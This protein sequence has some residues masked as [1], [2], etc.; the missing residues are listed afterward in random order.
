MGSIYLENFQVVRGS[1]S[2]E[3]RHLMTFY[4]VHSPVPLSGLLAL[5]V[6]LLLFSSCRRSEFQGGK[7]ML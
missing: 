7:G 3:Q 6:Q 4:Y 1:Y 2:Y 5:G